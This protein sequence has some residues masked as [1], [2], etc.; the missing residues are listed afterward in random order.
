[1]LLLRTPGHT[2]GNQTLFVNGD[3]G[4]F[5]C[6]ENGTSADNWSPHRSRLPGMRSAARLLD[7]EVMPNTNT[8]ELAAEQYTSMLLERAIVDRVTDDSGFYQMFPSSEVTHSLIAPYVKPTYRFG[9]ME[10]GSVQV[11]AQGAHA[12]ALGT[13][14][15]E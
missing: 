7:L 5:G 1:M 4:V 13:A 6:S 15:A 10:S 14:A 8:P 11:R 12:A 9:K 3:D 2:T